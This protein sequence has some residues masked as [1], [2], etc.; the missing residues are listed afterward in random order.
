MMLKPRPVKLSWLIKT[1]RLSEFSPTALISEKLGINWLMMFDE[2]IYGPGPGI[3][4]TLDLIL[5]Y[6]KPKS[7]L[8]LFGGSG[9]LSR[10]ASIRDVK[11]ITYVDLYPDAAILNLRELS[12]VEIIRGDAMDFL[13]L[14]IY[15]V[16]VADPPREL[17][18]DFLEKVDDLRKIFR[19][20]CLVWIG[21]VEEL[22]ERLPLLEGRR[23]VKIIRAWGD[24]FA[25]LWKPGLGNV[26]KHVKDLLE[27][28]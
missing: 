16:V 2:Y 27:Y 28:G 12:G 21:D 18:N 9:A 11:R 24:C 10:L 3:V 7:F 6:I 15:D 20:A 17:I 1:G 26:I 5:K 13:G 22:K 4:E 23:M 14:G 25:A 8:D 19:K